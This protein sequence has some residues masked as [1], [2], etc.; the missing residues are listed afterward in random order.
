MAAGPGRGGPDPGA[1]G[2]G[3]PQAADPTG[4]YTLFEAIEKQLG[5]KL[6]SQKRPMQ[7]IVI[8]HLEQKANRELKDPAQDRNTGSK[9]GADDSDDR[10]QLR[11]GYEVERSQH[12]ADFE[13]TFAEVVA[14]GFV[15]DLRRFL[16][17]FLRFIL[18]DLRILRCSALFSL[19]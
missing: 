12:Q 7:V 11:P 19:A 17:L 9:H 1:L 15:F 14:Q 6:E 5:L 3:A 18:S 10:E 13:Q 16:I 2:A 8:D 4:S